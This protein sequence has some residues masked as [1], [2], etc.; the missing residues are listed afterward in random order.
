M[1]RPQTR[2]AL[3][4][5]RQS[6][7]LDKI[8]RE[9]AVR[10]SDLVRMLGVSDMTIRRDLEAMAGRGLVTKVH[11]GATPVQMGASEEPGFEVN[12]GRMRHEK[13]R[14][15]RTAARLVQPNSAVALSAGTTTWALAAELADV[16][17]LTIVTNSLQVG[18]VLHANERADQ[19]VVITGGVRTPS[20]AL[21]GPV[22]VSAIR[23]LH[24]DVVFMG[25]HGIDPY[26]GIT[27]PNLLEGETNK[28][29]REAG[30]RLVVVADHTKW[31]VVGLCQIA[32]LADIDTW[33][34]D[35]TPEAAV[36]ELGELAPDVTVL[37]ADDGAGDDADAG[38]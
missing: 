11:G 37:V 18:D 32:A 14:I 8:N 5:E 26:A 31:G 36:R 1:T 3:A 27:T 34:V 35:E 4:A 12:L 23:S 33:V 6:L 24:V 29:L 21:V 38:V 7:I 22:A 19:T 15:A 30:R 25:V 17:G 28:A 9:G 20:D 13:Q 2:T 16:P 10:V